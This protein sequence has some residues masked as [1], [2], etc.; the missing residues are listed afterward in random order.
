MSQPLDVFLNQEI[1]RLQLVIG[2]VRQ[3]SNT[4]LGAIRGEVVITQQIIDGINAIFDAKVP[5]DW[6]FSPAG[7]EVS[8]QAPTIG[9]WA[10]GLGARDDQLRKWI[11][12]KGRPKSYWFPGWSNAAGFLTAVQQEVTRRHRSEGWALDGVRVDSEVTEY[13]R[14]E[15]VR[16]PPPEGVYISGLSLDGAIWDKSASAVAEA[17]PKILFCEMPILFV[18]AVTKTAKISSEVGPFG[19]F[20]CPST[21]MSEG[22][23]S[24]SSSWSTCP[25][26]RSRTADPAGVALLCYVR[27]IT[28]HTSHLLGGARTWRASSRTGGSWGPGGAGLARGGAR[29]ASSSD[30]W[31]ASSRAASSP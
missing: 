14:A 7:D 18:T 1:Q 9:F 26:S 3:K 27:E 24:T 13:D 23:T 22:R 17:K 4:I 5:H 28:A 31:S 29:A 16:A 30:A 11:A 8:W 25:R 20:S 21:S 12:G 19:G 2:S 10:S 6:V 15:Q